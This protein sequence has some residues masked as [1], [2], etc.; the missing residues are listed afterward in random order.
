MKAI[1]EKVMMQMN[2]RAGKP[3]FTTMYSRISEVPSRGAETNASDQAFKNGINRLEG[4]W[5]DQIKLAAKTVES[6][7][8]DVLKTRD[9]TT[10]GLAAIGSGQM[11]KAMTESLKAWREQ[12]FAYAHPNNPDPELALAKMHEAV[13][14]IA[15]ELEGMRRDVNR[16]LPIDENHLPPVKQSIEASRKR[17]LEPID[18][19]VRH[20]QHDTLRL[21]KAVG[22]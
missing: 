11:S 5:Y 17:L 4:C 16:I 6:K 18:A 21:I 19:L 10:S 14:T 20:L 3:T 22:T 7:L 13:A 8:P 1:A 12:S 9:M 2:A 15:F